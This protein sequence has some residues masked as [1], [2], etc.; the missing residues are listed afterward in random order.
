MSLIWSPSLL[1]RILHVFSSSLTDAT[2]Q[3][4]GMYHP[5]KFVDIEILVNLRKYHCLGLTGAFILSHF[6]HKIPISL[7][8]VVRWLGSYGS[9]LLISA[10]MEST[11]MQPDQQLW[12]WLFLS[13][14][15]R[16]WKEN[17]MSQP[18]YIAQLSLTFCYLSYK[19]DEHDILDLLEKVYSRFPAS[20]CISHFSL[21]WEWCV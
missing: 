7:N 1:Q 11:S 3:C 5:F 17:L 8:S 13:E 20:L 2:F 12:A 9:S 18:L 19:R 21:L 14:G 16:A 6:I 10:K 15:G 4:T